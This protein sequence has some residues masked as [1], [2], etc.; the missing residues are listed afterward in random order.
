MAMQVP[1]VTAKH[2]IITPVCRTGR[3]VEGAFDEAVRRLREEYLACQTAG[4]AEA[5]FH[6]VLTVE[7]PA[8]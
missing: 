4:N 6:L 8:G 1:G 2:A 7:R 3:G 5:S